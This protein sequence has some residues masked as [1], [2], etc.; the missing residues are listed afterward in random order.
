[1]QLISAHRLPETRRCHWDLNIPT[2]SHI[3]LYRE[4]SGLG[5]PTFKRAEAPKHNGCPP[6]PNFQRQEA[7]QEE[8][9]SLGPHIC[10]ERKLPI[11]HVC[12]FVLLCCW[13]GFP[14]EKELH[15][16]TAALGPQLPND[17]NNTQRAAAL[18]PPPPHRQE[19]TKKTAALRA[20][21]S[22]REATQRQT[23]TFGA[24]FSNEQNPSR[25]NGC[26]GAQLPNEKK[27]PRTSGCPWASISLKEEGTQNKLFFFFGGGGAT[28]KR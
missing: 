11:I 24:Q 8:L 21:I 12:H 7:T 17:E 5:A 14:N 16:K 18:W 26:F 4:S 23:D 22:Q 10:N 2:G 19:G 1:M 3:Y 6:P 27:L 28:F 25:T 9:L 15:I 20:Q 13:G